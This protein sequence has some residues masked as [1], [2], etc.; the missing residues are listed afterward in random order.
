MI[1]RTQS[2]NLAMI[3]N[4]LVATPMRSMYRIFQDFGIPKSTGYALVQRMVILGLVRRSALNKPKQPLSY[5]ITITARGRL[6]LRKAA[7]ITCA[8]SNTPGHI[9]IARYTR[10]LHDSGDP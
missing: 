2:R 6:Y 10:I 4:Q 9:E 5:R 8:A 1:A 3:L 7:W